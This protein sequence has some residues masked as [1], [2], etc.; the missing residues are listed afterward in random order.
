MRDSAEISNIKE[1]FEKIVGITPPAEFGEPFATA[2]SKLY[3]GEEEEIT[4]AALL[5]SLFLSAIFEGF[6]TSRL[7]T[8]AHY[9]QENNRRFSFNC[10][11]YETIFKEMDIENTQGVCMLNNSNQTKIRKCSKNDIFEALDFYSNR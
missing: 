3:N 1:A 7:H 6:P 5:C 10:N 11:M 2:F 8:F 9:A 4:A